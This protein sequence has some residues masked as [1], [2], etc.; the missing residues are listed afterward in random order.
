MARNPGMERHELEA[1]GEQERPAAAQPQ[2][3]PLSSMKGCTGERPL[4]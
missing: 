4:G 2:P 3:L 1:S